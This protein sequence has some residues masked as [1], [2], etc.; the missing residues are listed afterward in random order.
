MIR[1][2]AKRAN[3]RPGRTPSGSAV[4]QIAQAATSRN[5]LFEDRSPVDHLIAESEIGNMPFPF[6]FLQPTSERTKQLSA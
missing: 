1:N 3:R 2:F 4:S 6:A 5:T